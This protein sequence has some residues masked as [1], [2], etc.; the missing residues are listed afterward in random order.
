MTRDH[1]QSVDPHALLQLQQ[2]V[3]HDK[4]HSRHQRMVFL[5]PKKHRHSPSVHINMYNMY[6]T[7]KLFRTLSNASQM[8]RWNHGTKKLDFVIDNCR[9]DTL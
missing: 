6:Q 5:H 7:P 1:Q 4:S 2:S 9:P 8:Y 3:S